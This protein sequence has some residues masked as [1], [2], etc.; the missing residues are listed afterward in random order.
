MHINNNEYKAKKK[1]QSSAYASKYH[2]KRYG[3]ILR[4]IKNRG[5]LNTID[6]VLREIKK[7]SLVLDVPCGTG[8]LAPLILQRGFKWLGA[9]IS[10]EMMDVARGKTGGP[11]N[12]VGNVRLDSERMPFKSESIDCVASIRFIYHV[13]TREGRVSIL[14]EMR[15]IS[16][17]GVIIDYN[18]P[19]PIRVLYRKIGRLIRY[20]KRKRRLTMGEIA[21]E[22]SEAGLKI[23][24]TMPVSRI[25]SDNVIIFCSRL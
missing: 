9:D 24:K 20:P 5:T 15:R 10:F 21:S 1:Y 12:V 2:N 14:R 13:P 25:L 19:N 4:S 7:G 6:K 17:V 22:L 11:K 16:K 18:Y 8:R 3:G 23:E